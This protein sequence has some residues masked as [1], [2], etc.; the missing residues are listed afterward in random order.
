MHLSVITLTYKSFQFEKLD[1]SMFL[2]FLNNVREYK[3]NIT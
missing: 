2:S 3:G 1:Q